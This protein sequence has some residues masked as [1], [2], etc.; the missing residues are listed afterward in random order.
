MLCL[1]SQYWYNVV[2]HKSRTTL[3]KREIDII[4]ENYQSP[5]RKHLRK[6]T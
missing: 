4:R 2:L 5:K 3:Y 1:N 6:S